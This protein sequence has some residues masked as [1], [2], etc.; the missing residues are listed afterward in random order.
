MDVKS[1]A[2]PMVK[3]KFLIRISGSFSERPDNIYPLNFPVTGTI[4]TANLNPR[5]RLPGNFILSF[6][7]CRS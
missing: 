6:F 7:F 3:I 2:P 4:T 5:L 1:H